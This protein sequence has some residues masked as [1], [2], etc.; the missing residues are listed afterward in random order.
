M[1][2][3][4]RLVTKSEIVVRWAS[5]VRLRR[6]S[7]VKEGWTEVELDMVGKREEMVLGMLVVSE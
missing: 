7:T 5:R 6:D 3:V 4:R 2:K 1:I